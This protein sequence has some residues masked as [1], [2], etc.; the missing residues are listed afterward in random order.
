MKRNI[1][2]PA[3]LSAEA[4]RWW[5]Q[6]VEEYEIE[7]SGG[8]LILLTMFEAF[9]RMRAAQKIISEEDVS[10]SISKLKMAAKNTKYEFN[11]VTTLIWYT[12]I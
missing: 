1:R 6:L 10:H 4:R 9:D 12:T 5:R 3:G 2:A 11:I 7:D 8:R